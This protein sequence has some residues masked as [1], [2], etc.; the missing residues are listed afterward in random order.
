MLLRA[1]TNL[2]L[3]KHA[4]RI[5]DRLTLFLPDAS[6][7]SDDTAPLPTAA[8]PLELWAA[9]CLNATAL[10]GDCIRFATTHLTRAASAL[11]HVVVCGS[12][13][14]CACAQAE[15]ARGAFDEGLDLIRGLCGEFAWDLAESALPIA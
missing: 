1:T 4:P 9:C 12:P 6:T 7:M 13:L 8:S 11:A 2:T 14:A 5:A 10:Q 3:I 15:F